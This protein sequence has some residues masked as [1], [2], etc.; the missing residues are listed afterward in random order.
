MYIVTAKEMYEIEQSVIE[1]IGIPSASL[2]YA[3][4]FEIA[5][6]ISLET[7]KKETITVVCGYGNNGGDG[8]VVA[9]S[10]LSKGYSVQV[11]QMDSVKL[12]KEDAR[13]Y[14][15]VYLKS[16][17]RFRQFKTI[18]ELNVLLESTSIIIDGLVGIGISGCP[19]EPISSIIK[20]MN[21]SMCSIFSIDIPSG[22][23]TD[24]ASK[25]IIAIQANKT[26]VLG[27]YKMSRFIPAT[28][29]FY[30]D[31]ELIDFGL[32]AE[33]FKKYKKRSLSLVEAVRKS[34]PKRNE[35]SHKGS[36]GKGLIVG[37]SR[38]MPG[39]I[40][41]T[42]EASLRTGAGLVQTAT[43]QAAIPII[44]GYCPE[45]LYTPLEG[46]DTITGWNDLKVNDGEAMA[47]GPGI[48]RTKETGVFF[49]EVLKEITIPLIIDADGL[50]HLKNELSLMK[51][52]QQNIV[53]TP[54][55]KEMAELLNV[56]VQDLLMN[57]FTMTAEFCKEYGVYVILKGKYT[58]MNAPDGRQKVNITGNAGL[59]KGGTGDV[60]TGIVLGLMLQD[61]GDL[62][63]TLCNAT[64]IHGESAD[65][66]IKNTHAEQDLMATDVILGIGAVYRSFK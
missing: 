25:E 64:Y 22:L 65:L 33:S 48:G 9:N 51:S 21:A 6:H 39:A 18:E 40:T 8:F 5:R 36:H 45:A 34:L 60:L 15:E 38:Y 42:T 1:E 61:D 2:M 50:Y 54:H 19:K 52:K 32:P 26:Y 30:G 58:I 14:K 12:M 31:A 13:L 41:M 20:S 55:P 63:Q 35:F 16:G 24:S 44:A 4:G 43:V 10:L 3:A 66:L 59:A 57:P 56:S 62:F 27:A 47:I 11:V 37:G 28:A 23:P 53:L 49:K 7:Q 29:S 17:G 46:E